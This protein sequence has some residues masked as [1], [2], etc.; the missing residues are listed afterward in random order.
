MSLQKEKLLASQL[1]DALEILAKNEIKYKLKE[2][3]PPL[4]NIK[5]SNSKHKRVIRIKEKADF[6]E[7]IWSFQYNR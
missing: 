3:K 7:I 4:K 5:K 1:G 2:T 6:L